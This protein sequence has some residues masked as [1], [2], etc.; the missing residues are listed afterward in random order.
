MIVLYPD[1]LPFSV[2]ISRFSGYG[3]ARPVDYA[4]EFHY[5]CV[6]QCGK[7]LCRLFAAVAAAAVYENK[8]ILVRQLRNLI[9]TDSLVR[10][11]DSVGNM[12]FLKLLLKQLSY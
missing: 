11:T 9:R 5:I 6:A 4:A 8:L 1:F 10:N 12:L 7:L 3:F 2:T